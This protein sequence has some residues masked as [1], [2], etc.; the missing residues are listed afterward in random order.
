MM[1]ELRS[2]T[3]LKPLAVTP[4]DPAGIGPDIAVMLQASEINGRIVIIA[5]RNV[6]LERARVLGQEFN[7]RNYSE[8][9][10][11][12]SGI[13]VLHVQCSHPVFPGE[14]DPRNSRY[15]L[16]TLEIAAQGCLD[17]NFDAL[18]TGPVNKEMI[19]ISGID[20][21]GHTEF[22]AEH[23]QCPL[24][25]MLLTDENLRVAL[26]T[27]H[28]P[29]AQV[30]AAISQEKIMQ[31]ARILN[32]DL[33]VRFHIPSP[34]IGVCG[35]NPHAGEGGTL[36]TE[37]VTE[38]LPAVQTLQNEGVDIEGPFPADT[39]F[40]QNQLAN[41]DVVLAMYHDQGLPVIK[42]SAF[43]HAVNVTLGLPIIRT[44]VDH[45]TAYD[46]AGTGQADRGS[47]ISAVKLARN[48]CMRANSG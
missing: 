33:K 11:A 46:I 21:S 39:I 35:L 1:E 13:E 7:W 48:L 30:S 45:G 19:R 36:G 5:D 37:D 27:T 31:V 12:K 40:T 32:N 16:S 41:F 4:G 15:I 38:I 10:D 28:L 14:P 29:L 42:H 24:P 26:V 22:L 18:V 44:S 17:G 34:R 3:R 9:S 47:L 6:L 43:G 20:F 2:N 23:T 8:E 25:V